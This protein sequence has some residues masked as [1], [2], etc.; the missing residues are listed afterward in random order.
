MIT[1][2]VICIILGILL[3]FPASREI[4]SGCLIIFGAMGIA[5]YYIL[6]VAAIV[7][8]PVFVIYILYH[9]IHKLW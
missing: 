4:L 1:F 5:L 3:A 6:I 9:F 7:L 2:L 8:L